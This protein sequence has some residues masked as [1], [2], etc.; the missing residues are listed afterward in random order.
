MREEKRRR[1]GSGWCRSA[2]LVNSGF[3]LRVVVFGAARS[4]CL[5]RY[6]PD[7]VLGPLDVCQRAKHVRRS[8]ASSGVTPIYVHGS[9]RRG[10]LEVGKESVLARGRVH[11]TRV[12]GLLCLGF[13]CSSIHFYSERPCQ[14]V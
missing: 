6:T 12:R 13:Y 4:Y 10:S 5:F 9:C 7:G 1:T 2:K 11:V 3:A 8:A 14:R